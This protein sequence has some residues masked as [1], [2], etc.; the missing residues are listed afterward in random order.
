MTTALIL[1]LATSAFAD[2]IMLNSGDTV[3]AEIVSVDH[4]GM[5]VK[6]AEKTVE[7]A[8]ADLD[9]Q[10][11]YGEWSDR[12]GKDAESH[13][14]LAVFA[15]EN[16]M[17]NQARS[18]YRKAQALDKALVE[19]FEAEIVPQIKEGIAAKLLAMARSAFAAKDYHKAEEIVAKILTRLEDTKAA[20][21]ARDILADV[22][23]WELDHD[24]E[25]LL[26]RLTQYL[27]KDEAEALRVRDRIASRVAPIEKRIDNARNTVTRGLRTTS[28]N[29]SKDIFKEAGLEFE[30]QVKAVDKRVAEAGDDAALKEY[31]AG[32]REIA[33]R[34][35]VDAYLHAGNVY[36]V[37]TSFNDAKKMAA[38]AL[39]VDPASVKAKKF[40]EEVIEA[41]K[42]NSRWWTTA[43]RR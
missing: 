41:E 21:E 31:L 7:Y 33:V 15:F 6:T 26:K 24:Q 43:A 17:F 10:Y 38:A 29:R 11:Y 18:H 37:R 32:V 13:L 36:M 40:N 4:T 2:E 28:A 22:H 23:L 9:P 12:A 5:T 27:P 25:R 16:G 14:R 39:A 42:Q 34:E 30:R 8:P 19:K 35:G 1:L 3:E 20:A